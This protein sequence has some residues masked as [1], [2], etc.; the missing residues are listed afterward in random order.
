M[1]LSTRIFITCIFLIG[2]SIGVILQSVT[3]ELV[4]GMRQSLEEVLVDTANL[5]AEIV[6]QEVASDKIV[7]GDFASQMS[8]FGLRR[9]NARISSLQKDDT[10]LRVYITDAA[11]KVI[12]DSTGQ[13]RGDDYSQWNDVYLTLRGRYGA[14]TTR[15]NPKDA[16]SSVMYV[17][18]PIRQH[19]QIIGVISVGKPSI[20]VQPYFE[21]AVSNIETRV[22]IVSSISLLVVMLFIYWVTLSIR[23][24]TD[25]ARD[26]QQ[27]KRSSVPQLREK[28]L[29]QLASAMEAMR[30]SLE[31][32]NYV[33]NYLHSLTHELKSPLAAI[34][35]AVELLQEELPDEARKKFIHNIANESQRMRQVVEQLLKLASLE[36]RQQ[37][38]DVEDI[39]PGALTLQLCEDK[40]PMLEQKRLQLKTQI[41]DKVIIKAEA[42]LVQ[43]AISNLLD[44]AIEFSYEQGQIEIWTELAHGQWHLHI[45]D[46]GAGIP[47]YAMENIFERFY[48][49]PRPDSHQ[50]STGLGLSLV[51]EVAQLH[52]GQV[53]I[54]NV[55]GGGAE[56]ILSL[57][58][59]QDHAA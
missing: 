16:T 59:T 53:S 35:G 32:K 46:H 51:Y 23:K 10:N 20:S 7:K 49:L 26:V 18:A 4:P 42:F 21:K 22:A 54:K 34:Q 24:L 15:S 57:P 19:D 5:L 48:S 50:K 52:Q 1:S 14:R 36:K 33:E 8:A 38:Q 39:N 43:Q 11:G 13:N 44:N 25:Y 9:L 31:G 29:A 40:S 45:R 41:N 6:Q 58:L 2:L 55:E 27:G 12:Y 17:A 28:E 3:D 47:G 30:V 37:L 56:S